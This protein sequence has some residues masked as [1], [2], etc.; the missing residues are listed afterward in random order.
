MTATG[1]EGVL[2]GE[3]LRLAQTGAIFFN[4][5][6]SNREIDIEW[7]YR[8]THQRM[9]AHIERFDLPGGNHIFLLGKGSLL[10]LAAGSGASGS[11]RV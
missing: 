3:Q 11:I 9:R 6:H 10:N 1:V 5:G 4:A 2:G 7:L 8:Q